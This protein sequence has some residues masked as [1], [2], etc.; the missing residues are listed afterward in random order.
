MKNQ[1][2][3]I[4]H[5][6]IGFVLSLFFFCIQSAL[7]ASDPD[8]T[9]NRQAI[10]AEPTI[11]AIDL[12]NATLNG[13]PLRE[14]TLDEITDIFG[15]P[16]SVT[17]P[18]EITSAK[19]EISY[20]GAVINYHDKGLHFVFTSPHMDKDQHLEELRISLSK[21]M[22]AK[23]GACFVPYQG[24]LSRDVNGGWKAK[25]VSEVFS[26]LNLEDLWANAKPNREKHR[27]EVEKAKAADPKFAEQVRAIYDGLEKTDLCL[28]AR[29]KTHNLRFEYEQNTQFI[30]NISIFH[31]QHQ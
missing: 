27:L 28:F 17:D 15:R 8:P 10:S 21:N 19:N 18:K 6:A 22:D 3:I 25:K 29:L 24:K 11:D 12:V 5:C 26:D 9:T 14:L 4:I 7:L 13:R 1:I 23:C 16:S 30:E 20:Y 31:F 2:K